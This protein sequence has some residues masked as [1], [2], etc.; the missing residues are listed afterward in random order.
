MLL[1]V[2][3]LVASE[4]DLAKG[5]GDGGSDGGV[6]V[7]LADSGN[8]G[9]DLGAAMCGGVEVKAGEK[10]LGSGAK[11]FCMTSKGVLLL[12]RKHVG[13]MSVVILVCTVTC[14]IVKVVEAGG[15]SPRVRLGVKC[16]LG[17]GALKG[18]CNANENKR[19]S[20]NSKQSNQPLVSYL[21]SFIARGFNYYLIDKIAKTLKIFNKID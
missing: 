20:A 17:V 6:G 9:K 7:G 16:R 14:T 13:A 1:D 18:E 21:I 15:V 11:G 8:I 3:T 4:T 10:V 12:V 2:A 5:L 19:S